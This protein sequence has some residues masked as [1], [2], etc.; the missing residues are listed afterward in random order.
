METP[1][2][3]SIFFSSSKSVS[4]FS[5]LVKACRPST[6]PVLS[7]G[8]GLQDPSGLGHSALFK[9]PSSSVSSPCENVVPNA[10]QGVCGGSW[11]QPPTFVTL[12]CHMHPD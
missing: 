7:P 5:F 9:L 10:P 8:C 6:E 1:L 4:R 2:S 12:G 3:H 11:S